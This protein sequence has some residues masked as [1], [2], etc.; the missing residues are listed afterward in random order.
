M[1]GESRLSGITF[2]KGHFTNTILNL[3]RLF[4]EPSAAHWQRALPSWFATAFTLT[5][6]ACMDPDECEHWGM[7]ANG[8]PAGW[9]RP[10]PSILGNHTYAVYYAIYSLSLPPE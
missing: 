10:R 3:D 5:K 6:Y 2:Q 8:R 1:S 4:D 7:K 9:P